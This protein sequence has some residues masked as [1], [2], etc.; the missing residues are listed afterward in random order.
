MAL[1]Y[2]EI[3]AITE[4]YFRPKLV[5]NIFK[6]N[7][8][9]A[10]LRDKQE[11]IDG[12]ERML[13]PVMYAT[14]TATGAYV[15][16]DTLDVTPNDQIT[17]AEF[18]WKQYYANITITGIDELRNAGDAAKVSFVKSKVQVAEKSLAY[19]MGNDVYSLGTDT[20]TLDGLRHAVNVG[21]GVYGGAS[22]T[23]AGIDRTA[24]SW[25]SAQVDSTTTTLSI[26]KMES[27]FG[28][29]TIGNVHPTLI[30]T[31]Q[32]IWDSYLALL[33]P[34]Q[35]FVDS[36]MADAGWANLTFR[37]VPVVVDNRCPTGYM[38]MLNEDYLKLFTHSKR[39]FKFE[40]FIK[41]VNQDI[42]T[43]KI[44]WAGIMGCDN[45]RLQGVMTAIT[46]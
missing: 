35:R 4:K 2:N 24:Y 3:S 20:K 40:P 9:L 7:V 34:Q 11:K 22:A 15:G 12:G 44:Y 25:W 33:Q 41:P 5:D 36:K 1:S 13:M 30:V 17:S 43:S 31:T 45:P 10:R 14:T 39:D 19:A 27:L 6:S 32:S 8:L 42:A 21:S 37:S 18:L 46:A 38:F 26:A 16:A 28:L 29:C 23:Y